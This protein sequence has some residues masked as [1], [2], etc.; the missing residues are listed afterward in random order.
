MA[1]TPPTKRGGAI[2]KTR[3]DDARGAPAGKGTVVTATGGRIGNPPYD[4]E[5]NRETVRTHAKFFPP[6]AEHH[7]AV[8]LGISRS[9][10]RRHHEHDIALGRA[11]ML[12]A[13]GAQVITA[14]LDGSAPSAKGDRDLQKYILARLGGWSVK[15]QISG[16]GGGP[17]ETVDLSN[18]TPEQLEEYGRLAAAAEGR[19]QDGD[20]DDDDA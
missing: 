11:Q 19:D 10:L 3:P 14:A 20:F 8:L 17:I 1:T 6:E 5:P 12:A 4:P 7:I 15:A 13:V 18:L 2:P 9:T 16:K